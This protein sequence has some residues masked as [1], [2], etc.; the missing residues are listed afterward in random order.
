MSEAS[1]SGPTDAGTLYWER[2]LSDVKDA[3][4]ANNFEAYVSGSAA[5]ARQLVVDEIL[6]TLDVRTFSRSGSMTESAVGLLALMR[7]DPRYEFIEPFGEA[8]ISLE[9]RYEVA[10]RSIAVDLYVT[11]SNAITE[12]GQLVNL[13]MFG[14]RITG[15]NYG[16]RN[17]IVLAGRNKVAPDLETAMRRVRQVVAPQLGVSFAAH[18]PGA[19]RPCG[20][21]SRC[22][23]CS[24]PDRICNVWSIV[25][26]CYPKGRIKVILINEDLGL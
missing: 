26:K 15:I 1:E 6:P 5:S 4:D 18:D 25:E 20:K 7:E 11:G 14:N 23:D 19:A 2:R 3:L 22:S 9:E 16:P 12:R 8:E 13:D 17:T 10:K 24:A 21:T